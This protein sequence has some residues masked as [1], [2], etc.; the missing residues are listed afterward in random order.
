MLSPCCNKWYEC[1]E[2]HDEREDHI[3]RFEPTLRFTCKG[4]RKCFV[5][6]FKL[7]S[8][9]D[10][11]CDF[12]KAVWCKPAETPESKL[13]N[14]SNFTFDEFLKG[15]VDVNNS[16]YHVEGIRKLDLREYISSIS[17]EGSLAS[18]HDIIENDF[19]QYDGNI[20]EEDSR[21]DR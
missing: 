7:F 5:R 9:R 15:L 17:Q 10:K 2:C 14:E 16:L 13:Y 20:E 11:A 1:A 19:S 3:F 8:E 18:H 21:V 4:C 6:D 12:C